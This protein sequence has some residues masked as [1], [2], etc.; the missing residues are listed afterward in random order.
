M[1]WMI[2]QDSGK[3]LMNNKKISL[4]TVNNLKKNK[5]NKVIHSKVHNKDKFTQLHLI[6]IDFTKTQMESKIMMIKVSTLD[7]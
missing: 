5:S 2:Y 4:L 1:K 6:N 3:I 7:I